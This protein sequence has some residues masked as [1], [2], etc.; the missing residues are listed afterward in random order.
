M[1]ILEKKCRKCEITKDI[2]EFSKKRDTKDGYRNKCKE[3]N[4]KYR[5]E[6]KNYFKKWRE[7]NKYIMKEYYKVYYEENK[8]I[9]KERSKEWR[10]ENR[11][12]LIEYNR[13]WREENKDYFNKYNRNRISNDPLFKLKIN[14]RNLIGNSLRN[15]FYKKDNKTNS[16][17]GCSYEELLEHLNDNKYGFI[18]G[19]ENLDIDH[20]IPLSR[21]TS[22]EEIIELNHYSNLQLL[23]SEYNRYIKRDKD[24][25]RDCLEEWLEN[26]N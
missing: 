1:N 3:C 12:K 24:F 13:E 22:E 18:Y 19:D 17:L 16:I 11:D 9:I 8:E 23:P 26:K 15:G 21:A 6:N 7:E 20:I 2:K 14:I 25:D 5:E 4:K 10:E